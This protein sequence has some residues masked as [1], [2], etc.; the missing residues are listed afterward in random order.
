MDG[1]MRHQYSG[2]SIL[3]SGQGMR[4]VW[5]TGTLMIRTW[6]KS[7]WKRVFGI[8]F[9]EWIWDMRIALLSLSLRFQKMSQRSTAYMPKR[10]LTWGLQR[11]R[12]RLRD[13]KKGTGS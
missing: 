1:M 9:W 8:T 13:S 7:T 11:L 2:G 3:E 5:F 6:C 12:K 10:V 4:R